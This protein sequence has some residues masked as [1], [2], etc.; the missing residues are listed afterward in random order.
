VYTPEEIEQIYQRGGDEE[1]NRRLP[2]DP[3]DHDPETQRR[4]EEFVKAYPAIQRL[5]RH[6]TQFSADITDPAGGKAHGIEVT[7]TNNRAEAKRA[8]ER[9]LRSIGDR[10]GNY[11]IVY[12]RR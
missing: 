4:T 2:L 11:H 10:P 7:Y 5:P 1:A 8:F 3:Y 6:A 12:R 9:W